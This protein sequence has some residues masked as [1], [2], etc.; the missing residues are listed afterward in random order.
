MERPDENRRRRGSGPTAPARAAE[1][2]GGDPPAAAAAAVAWQQGN[3]AEPA[4]VGGGA[5]QNDVGSGSTPIRC[6]RLSDV[7]AVDTG[8]LLS[9]RTALHMACESTFKRGTREQLYVVNALLD[10][11]AHTEVETPDGHTPLFCA[12]ARGFTEVSSL[13]IDRGAKRKR[14]VSSAMDM[15]M[16]Q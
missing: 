14:L 8:S 11:G 7:N 15:G 10:A 13:L 12:E 2:S 3:R 9:R 16:R 1:D 6:Q 4:E 5:A